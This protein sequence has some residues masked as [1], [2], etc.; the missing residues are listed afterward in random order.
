MQSTGKIAHVGWTKSP[1]DLGR[2]E[3]WFKYLDSINKPEYQWLKPV[4]FDLGKGKDFLNDNGQYQAVILHFIFRGGFY[5]KQGIQ[6]KQSA[7]RISELSSWGAWRKRLAATG[8]D[9][10]TS[11][12]G[13]SEVS[14]SY[15]CDVPSYGKA[16]FEAPYDY[17]LELPTLQKPTMAVFHRQTS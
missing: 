11:F 16:T 3:L 17:R 1:E 15:L 7:L 10:I 4:F 8:A 6:V 9:Y 14:G 13:I 2:L 12:G 5:V